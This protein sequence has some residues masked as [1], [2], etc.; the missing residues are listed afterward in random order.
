MSD[1]T[2]ERLDALPWGVT[3]RYLTDNSDETAMRSAD[4]WRVFIGYQPYLL[5]SAE[6]AGRI[7]EGIVVSVPVDALL[8]D[9]AIDAV[10]DAASTWILHG[11]PGNPS[12]PLHIVRAA[13]A[14]VTGDAR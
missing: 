7:T 11:V 5:T 8:S 13:I 2:S 1:W 6:L 14:H 12:F 9:E 4:G 3:L 10:S